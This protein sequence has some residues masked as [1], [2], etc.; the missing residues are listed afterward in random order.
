MPDV[1]INIGGRDFEVACQTGEEHYLKSAAQMLDT[2]ASALGA[3]VGR[4]PES[5]ML[6]MAGLMLADRTAGVEDQLR[7]VE[8][9]MAKMAA[10]LERLQAAPPASEATDVPVSPADG[11]R[12]VLSPRA[13]EALEAA[14]GRIEAMAEE[15]EDRLAS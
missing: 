15:A 13:V 3:Q 9:R 4:L 8:D 12:L 6:L 10:E 2:E 5:R 14:A 11:P 1:T 7:V